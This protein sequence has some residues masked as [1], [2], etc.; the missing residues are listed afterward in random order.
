MLGSEWQSCSDPSKPS[1]PCQVLA[2]RKLSQPFT[3]LAHPTIQDRSVSKLKS[4]VDSDT[5]MH[6]MRFFVIGRP[7]LRG[8]HRR[9]G[10]G[11][12][13]RVLSQAAAGT[14]AVSV[15]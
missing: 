6:V 9:A 4:R 12:L 10:S 15:A 11:R 8:I 13:A 1:E 3:A 14:M 2:A 5:Y 7:E